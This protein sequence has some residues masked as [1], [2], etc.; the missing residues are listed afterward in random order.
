MTMTPADLS[1]MSKRAHRK[2]ADLPTLAREQEYEGNGLRDRLSSEN[3]ADA[4]LPEG[5]WAALLIAATLVTGGV[6]V[7]WNSLDMLAAAIRA[8]A[9]YLAGWL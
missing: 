5:W 2:S 8:A 6:W 7:I 1:R 3:L 9:A 4:R